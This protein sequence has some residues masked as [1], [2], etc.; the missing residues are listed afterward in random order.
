MALCTYCSRNS[1]NRTIE[2]AGIRNAVHI[3]D[4]QRLQWR[5][6]AFDGAREN[7]GKHWVRR[8]YGKI[9]QA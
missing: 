7:M 4:R 1:A 8:E 2:T 3:P 6:A 5:F 9:S